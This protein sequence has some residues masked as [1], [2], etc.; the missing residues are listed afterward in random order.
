MI[1]VLLQSESPWQRNDAIT[2]FIYLCVSPCTKKE[3][4]CSG[5]SRVRRILLTCI[6]LLL[7]QFWHVIWSTPTKFAFFKKHC[8]INFFIN[9]TIPRSIVNKYTLQASRTLKTGKTFK[10]GPKYDQF[11][12]QI[13]CLQVS[14]LIIHWHCFQESYARAHLAKKKKLHQKELSI[15]FGRNI[16][17]MLITGLCHR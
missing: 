6:Q 16:R 2:F 9:L 7:L 13:L 1:W 17:N 4:N 11:F 12:P 15:T 3:G 14:V 10:Q 5:R 8:S